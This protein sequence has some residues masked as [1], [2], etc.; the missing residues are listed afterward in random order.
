MNL[1]SIPH[2]PQNFKCLYIPRVVMVIGLCSCM[3]FLSPCSNAQASQNLSFSVPFTFDSKDGSNPQAALTRDNAGNLYGIT[4]DG[5]SG[6]AGTLFRL[7]P[8]GKQIVLHNFAV[9]SDGSGPL[10]GVT[11]DGKGNIYGTTGAGGTGCNAGC[12]V[13]YKI[14]SAGHYSVL[15]TFTGGSDGASPEANLILDAAGNIYGTTSSGGVT[16][17]GGGH[18]TAFELEANGVFDLLYTFQGTPDASNP[19]GNLIRDSAGNIYG[20]TTAGGFYDNGTVFK[21]DASGHET[22]LHSFDQ[23]TTDGSS[24]FGGLSGDP[25]TLLYGTTTGGGTNND[26]T[27]FQIDA[28]GNESIL[29]SFTG[30]DGSFPEAALLSV[31]GYL[32]GTTSGGGKDSCGTVFAFTPAQGIEVLHQFTCG[33]D[34]GYPS[35]PLLLDGAGTMYGS[36][37]GKYPCTGSLCGTI[38]KLS[39]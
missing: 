21:I 22:V 36:T 38:F 34:G 27:I 26:G 15:Y 8:S 25:A 37:Y 23:S 16:Q 9:G 18:G 35:A 14:D 39:R 19:T 6:A 3:L 2:L 10:A 5:G 1:E 29:H 4:V 12:G 11:L 7:S 31:Q 17:G 28:S 13:V 32:L 30:P 33:S 24:P 20:T